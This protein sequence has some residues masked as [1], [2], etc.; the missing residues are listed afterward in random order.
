MP[1]ILDHHI[2][3]TPSSAYSRRRA[4][5][6]RIPNLNVPPVHAYDQ[7]RLLVARLRGYREDVLGHIQNG[8]S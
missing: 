1:S 4:G 2:G 7:M 3:G 5:L 6:L 8:H